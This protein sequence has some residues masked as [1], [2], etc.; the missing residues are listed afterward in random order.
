MTR[1]PLVALLLVL[2]GCG[3][4]GGRSDEPQ[5]I[6]AATAIGLSGGTE[7]T[8]H[9]FFSHQPE[10]AMPRM[11]TE[12]SGAYPP[13]CDMPSLPVSNLSKQAENDLPLT[14]DPETG[15]RW[16]QQE[17]ELDGRI[18]DGALIVQ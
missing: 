15:A 3:G 6:D 2:A 7:V 8:V 4:S 10:E 11:C 12:L 5:V 14:R 18:E 13:A 1:A 9:G 16:T 17:I